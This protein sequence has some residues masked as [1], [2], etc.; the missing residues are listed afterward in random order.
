[1]GD[2][3]MNDT[4]LSSEFRQF[5]TSSKF[6]LR[7]F[8]CFL[9]QACFGWFPHQTK[10]YNVQVSRHHLINVE[11]FNLLYDGENITVK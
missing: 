1:M 3:H 11:P 7:L 4:E 6:Y 2:I 5:V 10:N 9:C 8:F